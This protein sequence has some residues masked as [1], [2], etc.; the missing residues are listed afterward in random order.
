[1]DLGFTG[2]HAAPTDHSKRIGK[3]I[4]RKLAREGVVRLRRAQG[5]R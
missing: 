1:M 2:K 5:R 4:A 3:A